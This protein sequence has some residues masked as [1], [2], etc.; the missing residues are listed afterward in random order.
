MS[1]R[2][3]SRSGKL[4][5]QRCTCS[6]NTASFA[7]RAKRRNHSDAATRRL[8]SES[9]RDFI[10]SVLEA[11]PS[12]RD[13]RSYLKAFAPRQRPP[14]PPTK[15]SANDAPLQA[16]RKPDSLN[17][18]AS[19]GGS[20]QPITEQILSDLPKASAATTSPAEASQVLLDREQFVDKL[21]NPVHQHTAIVKVQGPFTDRQLSSIA[22]GMVYLKKLGLVAIMSLDNEDWAGLAD[23]P[24][25][26]R[27]TIIA[28][29]L[30][31]VDKLETAGAGARPLIDDVFTI[32]TQSQDHLGVGSLTAIR[33]AL[34]H[35]EIPVI[36]PIALDATVAAVV[37]QSNAAIL[38]LTRALVEDSRMVKPQSPS[39]P[40]DA[41]APKPAQ[42][43]L[44]PLRM[45]IINREG[46]IP[47]PARAGNPHLSINLESE[48]DFIKDTFVW[49]DSHPSSLDNLT[50]IKDCLYLLPRESSA[51][52]VSHRSPKSLIANLVTNR[53][54]F[55]PSLKL[56]LLPDRVEHTPTIIKRGLPIRVV[57]AFDQLDQ[58]KLAELLDQSFGKTLV[59][60]P[61]FDRLKTC[62][63]FTI[64]AGDYQA[65]AIV[66]LEGAPGDADADLT[67]ISYLDKFAVLPSLQGDG[68][69]DFLWGALR[70]ESFGLG[71]L[72]A[73][74][75]NG[76][77]EGRGIGRDLVWRSRRDNPVNKWYFERSNGFA[78]VQMGPGGSDGTLFWADSESR[79]ERFKQEAK[80]QAHTGISTVADEE[81][82]PSGEKVN[83]FGSSMSP[84]TASHPA[85]SNVANASLSMI[86]STS[87]P[88][89][90][91]PLPCLVVSPAEAISS[92]S[93]SNQPDL[94][95][96]DVDGSIKTVLRRPPMPLLL[97]RPNKRTSI[98]IDTQAT[99][100]DHLLVYT[101]STSPM[102][103]YQSVA[104]SLWDE[105]RQARAHRS[106]WKARLATL[107]FAFVL[108]L[109]MV[110]FT[111]L[112]N[113][114]RI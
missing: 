107:L 8:A 7:Q 87:A 45:M 106:F 27:Q 95:V 44:T 16:E 90:P 101:N 24:D 35:G 91:L 93:L 50:L 31:L 96:E 85:L 86:S 19:L 66:T 114:Q 52:V 60:K 64:L 11:H 30:E 110:G 1:L 113:A 72:D 6:H 47:S 53:P 46:G 5:E 98:I 71:L 12:A 102:A 112:R 37:V 75:N 43:D 2:L 48:Y 38:A 28:E 103:S 69:V 18:W 92:G 26:L 84:C 51:V 79:L 81:V 21:L 40:D 42:V 111:T 89:L 68:T 41:L 83:A 13:S 14:S 97:V 57:R 39:H 54:S 9:Q 76:G 108:I 73:L 23:K 17:A 65:A 15:A 36:P 63:D 104:D 32:N 55:S 3:T 20:M 10:L 34:K 82:G 29:T 25:L 80:S 58:D 109:S 61:Y 74:N 78:H 94:N 56:D 62:M 105:D 4:A 70:D 49:Q 77:L 22:E 33:S 67:P 88:E 59:R 99:E 100:S